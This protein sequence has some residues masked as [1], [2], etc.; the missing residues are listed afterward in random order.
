M[1]QQCVRN[2]SK[3][4]KGL[5]ARGSLT[6]W[7]T[8]AVLAKW[9]VKDKSGQPGAGPTYTDTAI[10]SMVSLKNVFGLPGRAL[11]GLV[12]SV[13]KLMGIELSVPD[14]MT[15]SRGLKHLSVTLPVIPK[16]DK[17]H[18][19]IDSTGVKVYGEGEWK[20]RQHRVSKRRTWRKLHLAVDGTTSERAKGAVPR[21]QSYDSGS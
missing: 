21:P 20:A 1:A 18:V 17:R 19:V 14:H 4:N 2:W 5:E 6:F 3:Y 11:C 10:I 16:S 15:I 13:F 8:P 12:K 7:I 9:E